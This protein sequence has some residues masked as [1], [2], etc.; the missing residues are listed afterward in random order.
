M[1]KF[2][3]ITANLIK[4]LLLVAIGVIEHMSTLRGGL[5]HHLYYKK[6][7]H[8]NG[9]YS[10]SAVGIQIGIL[11]LL[12]LVAFAFLKR[13]G[14]LQVKNIFLLILELAALVLIVY[15]PVFAGLNTYVY[16]IMAVEIIIVI[17]F[18]QTIFRVKD[19]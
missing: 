8:L 11:A 16:L 10:P 6:M 14:K 7:Q 18:I 12:A 17:E 5:M 13:M 4:V 15:T 9:L 3:T 19:I 1:R 2:C